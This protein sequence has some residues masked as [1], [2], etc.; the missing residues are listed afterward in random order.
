[1]KLI[2]GLGN[3]G[4]KYENTRHNVGFMTTERLVG[5]KSWS[6]SKGAPLSYVQMKIES[7]PVEVIKPT[8]FMNESGQAVIGPL[9]K[10]SEIEI[11]DVYV[12]HDDLD[13]RL[14]E[15]KIQLGKGPREHKGV[16]SV[17]KHLGTA[18]F[19]RVR[20]GVDSR[21]R[22][23]RIPGESYV[24]MPFTQEEQEII[25]NVIEDV[26]AELRVRVLS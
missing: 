2:V 17:E 6:R 9:K 1:M 4:E 3:P 11:S 7:E 12:V 21:G 20:I 23:N 10:H 13:I 16:L 26:V 25:D 8:T 18:N 19:W 5:E 15:Y 14:G 24:L 22:E